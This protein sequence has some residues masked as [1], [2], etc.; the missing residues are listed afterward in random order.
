[1]SRIAYSVVS[2]VVLAAAVTAWTL[3]RESAPAPV[4]PSAPAVRA[5][6]SAPTPS[7]AP[8]AAVAPAEPA[9]T[10]ATPAPAQP[11]AGLGIDKEAIRKA[12]AEGKEQY[13]NA[14]F[15][16]ERH[17]LYVE[18]L[19]QHT[20]PFFER[21]G[22]G[23][24]AAK[25]IVAARADA[26]FAFLETQALGASGTTGYDRDATQAALKAYNAIVAE[27][28]DALPPGVTMGDVQKFESYM[29]ARSRL[30]KLQQRLR[31]TAEPMD[32][33]KVDSIVM[34]MFDHKVP[35][36]ALLERS[37]FLKGHLTDAQLNA[38]YPQ[39]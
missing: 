30:T 17:R 33:A 24:D 11:S 4:F 18:E 5:T 1:M 27:A 8:V 38:L 39:K 26:K 12:I 9:P 15:T 16:A 35:R 37:D 22:I 29:G 31:D 21:Y 2:V 28:A 34:D 13:K 3:S 20:K 32:Q 19:S 10:P 14:E 6:P 23:A 25:R 7:R 36:A